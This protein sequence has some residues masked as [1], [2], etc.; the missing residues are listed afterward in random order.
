MTL[1]SGCG[2]IALSYIGL[3]KHPLSYAVFGC[4]RLTKVRL[5]LQRIP[6]W[7][8]DSWQI[9][10]VTA[11]WPCPKPLLVLLVS[12]TI[13]CRPGHS[14]RNSEPSGLRQHQYE[15]SRMLPILNSVITGVGWQ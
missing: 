1:G 15:G 12:P 11:F 4:F 6:F 8:T 3:V 2:G 14:L 7:D 5:P 13:E 10:T 9:A